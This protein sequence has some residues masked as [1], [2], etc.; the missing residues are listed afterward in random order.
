MTNFQAPFDSFSD[1]VQYLSLSSDFPLELIAIGCQYA[2]DPVSWSKESNTWY[3]S[4]IKVNCEYRTLV[5][6]SNNDFQEITYLNFLLAISSY[7]E[8]CGRLTNYC[9]QNAD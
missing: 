3:I 6:N 9:S 7:L 5:P 8:L 2:I 4:G 1:A